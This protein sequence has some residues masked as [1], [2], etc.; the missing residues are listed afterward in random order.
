MW[1]ERVCQNGKVGTILGD[2]GVNIATWR[3][4]RSGP[5]ERALSFISVDSD[6]PDDVIA[7]LAGT[8][9]IERIAKVQL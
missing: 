3:T 9:P 5:G 6:V 8:E 2:L 4:G 1:R 7:Q